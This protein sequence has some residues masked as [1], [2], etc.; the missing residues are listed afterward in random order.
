VRVC[1]CVFVGVCVG[2]RERESECYITLVTRVLHD[3]PF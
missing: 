1:A 3:L 2:E